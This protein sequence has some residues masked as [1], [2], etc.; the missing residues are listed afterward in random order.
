MLCNLQIELAVKYDTLQ[1]KNHVNWVTG[2]LPN[3]RRRSVGH[4]LVTN[5]KCVFFYRFRDIISYFA[6][7]IK[8]SRHP[9]YTSFSGSVMHYCLYIYLAT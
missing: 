7:S 5:C 2:G 3:R 8:W 9:K 1:Y 6:K 4:T